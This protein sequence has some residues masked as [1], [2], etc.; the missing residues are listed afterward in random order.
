MNKFK[1]YRLAKVEYA[2]SLFKNKQC[3]EK[4]R[5]IIIKD[6]KL[7]LV[8]KIK[9]DKYTLPG[10]GV[11]IGE[12]IEIA[13]EREVME[14]TKA[15]VSFNSV[16]GILNYNVN[17]TYKSEKFTS[18]RIEYYCLCNF[19]NFVKQK[20]FY[21]LNGE[22]FEKVEVVWQKI[23]DLEKCGLDDYIVKKV[24]KLV[25]LKVK[26]SGKNVKFNP[27]AKISVRDGNKCLT[28]KDNKNSKN[29]GFFYKKRKKNQKNN[30]LLTKKE[31][32]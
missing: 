29:K 17:M 32:K 16:I 23:D 7:L 24:K 9:S 22:F 8:H 27:K 2:Y 25:M 26:N 12:N 3:F 4:V 19:K 13:V 5:A 11:E 28:I 1:L 21:G 14:E 10:G 30:K 31:E 18:T 20:R 6:N 15:K